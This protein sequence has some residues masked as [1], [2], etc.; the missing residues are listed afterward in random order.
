MLKRTFKKK[1]MDGTRKRSG[2]RTKKRSARYIIPKD[3]KIDYKN[4]TLL[5]KFVTDRGKLVSR[6]ISG[7]SGQQQRDLCASVKRARYLGLLPVGGAKK[8]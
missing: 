2:L 1:K 5:Q 8:K 7:I 4:L 6:R 3:T